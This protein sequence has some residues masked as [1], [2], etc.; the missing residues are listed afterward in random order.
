MRKKNA[1][2]LTFTCLCCVLIVITANVQLNPQ[3]I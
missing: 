1:P 2:Y 3:S